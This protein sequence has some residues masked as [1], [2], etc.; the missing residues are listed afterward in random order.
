MLT[1]NGAACCPAGKFSRVNTRRRAEWQI[2]LWSIF[3]VCF[4]GVGALPLGGA[5][6]QQYVS[7]QGPYNSIDA[8]LREEFGSENG[9]ARLKAAMEGVPTETPVSVVY[10]A[11]GFQALAGNVTTQLLWPRPVKEFRC[12]KPYGNDVDANGLKERG[13]VAVFLSVEPPKDLGESTRVGR[14]VQVVRIVPAR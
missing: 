13:G 3:L 2:A 14:S 1:R 10:C 6:R 12:S 8:A 5:R 11:S 4:V 9:S 7:D